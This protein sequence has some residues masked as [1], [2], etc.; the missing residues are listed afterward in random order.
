[1]LDRQGNG[2][3]GTVVA[4]QST[5]RREIYLFM[6]QIGT[7]VK[8]DENG[9]FTLPPVRGSYRVW[10]CEGAPDYSRRFV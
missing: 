9:C 2:V 7:A 4:L 5:E 10:V 8:T 3:G 1:M 6:I